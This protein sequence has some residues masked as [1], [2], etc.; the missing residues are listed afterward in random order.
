MHNSESMRG[1][2][3]GGGRLIRVTGWGGVG[4]KP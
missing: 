3:A 1:F 2:A 4:A